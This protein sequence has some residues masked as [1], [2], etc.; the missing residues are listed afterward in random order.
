MRA[1]DQ[2]ALEQRVLVDFGFL[3]R[4]ARRVVALL[5][6]L[7]REFGRGPIVTRSIVN[8]ISIVRMKRTSLAA[9]IYFQKRN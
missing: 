3:R 7:L 6:R 5:H 9:N 8:K 4:L 2:R 1:A